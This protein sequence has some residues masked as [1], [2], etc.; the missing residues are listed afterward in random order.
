MPSNRRGIKK[1]TRSL[2]RSQA[3]AFGIPLVPTD[4]RAQPTRAGIDGTEAEVAGREIEFFIV[5]RVV[6]NMHLAVN[7]AQGTVGIKNRGG[8]VIDAGS[9]FFKQGSD[10]HDSVFAGGLGE[11][12]R[13]GAGN[14]LG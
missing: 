8:I 4:E 3:G 13:S 6:R 10:E 7:A 1:H 11:P 14:R 5:E 9:S 2:Q 12:V